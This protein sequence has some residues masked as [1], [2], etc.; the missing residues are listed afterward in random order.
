MISNFYVAHPVFSAT[1][2]EV[3]RK[4]ERKLVL[5]PDLVKYPRLTPRH[6]N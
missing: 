4:R 1:A 3:R 6:I 5:T 2:T